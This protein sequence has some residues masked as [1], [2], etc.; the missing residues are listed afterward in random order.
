MAEFK[1]EHKCACIHTIMLL[2][3]CARTTVNE[4]TNP[5]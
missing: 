2:F 1:L 5:L 3:Y 4:N